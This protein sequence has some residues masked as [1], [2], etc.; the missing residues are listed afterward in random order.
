MTVGWMWSMTA[1]LASS[2]G[3]T[4]VPTSMAA[5]AEKGEGATVKKETCPRG[6]RLAPHPRQRCIVCGAENVAHTVEGRPFAVHLRTRLHKEALARQGDVDLAISRD[7]G[8]AA[9][10]ARVAAGAGPA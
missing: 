1:S 10:I 6:P 7:S 8:L 4:T 9:R 2:V 3:G 5:V